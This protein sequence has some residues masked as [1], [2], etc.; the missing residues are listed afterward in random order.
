M[1][2]LFLVDHYYSVRGWSVR[3]YLRLT[4]DHWCTYLILGRMVSDKKRLDHTTLTILHRCDRHRSTTAESGSDIDSGCSRW[5]A[6]SW[7]T[8]CGWGSAADMEQSSGLHLRSS[9]MRCHYHS[10]GYWCYLVVGVSHWTS[11]DSYFCV[12]LATRSSKGQTSPSFYSSLV[13]SC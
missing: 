6:Q 12:W 8:A 11:I 4:V 1:G 3:T 2:H 9:K 10:H 5:G 7:V 13:G